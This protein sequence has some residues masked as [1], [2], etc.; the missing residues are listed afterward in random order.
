MQEYKLALTRDKFFGRKLALLAERMGVALTVCGEEPSAW[1]AEAYLV[2]A[3]TYEGALPEGACL[4]L[5][6]RTREDCLPIPTPI[7]TVE[8]VL[9]GEGERLRFRSDMR[10]ASVGSRSVPLT[11]VESALLLALLEAKGK[12]VSAAA[13]IETVWKGNASPSCVNVYIHYLRQK[14][15]SGGE[16][17]IRSRRGEGYY[18]DEK[19]LKEG[20]LC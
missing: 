10:R 16:R 6:S 8:D 20:A 7:E 12:C 13:L 2:D 19:Y 17:I 11:E 18:V 5:F 3:D 9:R 4:Y 15:E 14:L 1:D